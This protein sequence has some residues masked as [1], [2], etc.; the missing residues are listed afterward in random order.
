MRHAMRRFVGEPDY[1][2]LKETDIMQRQG[3]TK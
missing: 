2:K 3:G 1:R